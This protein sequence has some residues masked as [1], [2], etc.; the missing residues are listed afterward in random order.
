MKIERKVRQQSRLRNRHCS[1]FNYS[2][3]W[4]SIA[5]LRFCKKL[6]CF[7]FENIKNLIY[8][9][10]FLGFFFWPYLARLFKWIILSSPQVQEPVSQTPL[11]DSVLKAHSLPPSIMNS[12]RNIFRPNRQN[13]RLVNSMINKYHERR[14]LMNKARETWLKWEEDKIKL[15]NQKIGE[16]KSVQ[17]KNVF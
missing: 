17:V 9:W 5:W 6:F 4:G 16:Q 13:D 11:G 15:R 14:A 8:N 12:A 2:D 10:Y 7:R 1:S 3:F